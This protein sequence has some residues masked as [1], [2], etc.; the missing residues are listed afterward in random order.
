MLC[1]KP[2]ARQRGRCSRCSLLRL[3]NKRAYLQSFPQSARCYD[4]TLPYQQA[5]QTVTCPT[6]DSVR[7]VHCVCLSTATA[8]GQFARTGAP[9]VNHLQAGLSARLIRSVL[10]KPTT[11]VHLMQLTVLKMCRMTAP[12]LS[13]QVT[14]TDRL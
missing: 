8:N 12:P 2:L 1:C 10:W 11:V 4:Q 14:G 7:P 3:Q 6:V 5:L 13:V 9:P